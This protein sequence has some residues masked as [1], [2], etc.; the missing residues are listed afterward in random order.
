L[1]RI[2]DEGQWLT[3]DPNTGFIVLPGGHTKFTIRRDKQTGTYVTLSNGVD[4]VEH[5]SNR[6]VLSLYSSK[7]LRTWQHCKTLLDD[8]LGLSW[9]DS[10]QLT[11][12]QYVDWQFD[13]EDILYLVR[14]AYDGAHNYH[15]ANRITFHRL[16]RFRDLL[17]RG[18]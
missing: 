9:R 8:D 1:V 2:E 10:A 12:F 18:I 4:D 17:E 13:G 14:T 5:S 11:G 6:A 3:F 7:D 15:D 16:T